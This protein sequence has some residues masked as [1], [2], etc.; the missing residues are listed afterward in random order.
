VSRLTCCCYYCAYSHGTI[1]LSNP[2]L[3][4][5]P[6]NYHSLCPHAH[7]INATFVSIT[8]RYQTH[9][10]VVVLQN[11]QWVILW[12]TS[13]YQDFL[14]VL[15]LYISL[16]MRQSSGWACSSN[17]KKKTTV[18]PLSPSIRSSLF[19]SMPSMAISDVKILVVRL[20]AI[21]L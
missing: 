21:W 20:F 10:V 3:M 2:I 1:V 16:V 7:G 8:A 4:A 6:F 19:C 11:R 17:D 12:T 15:L 14:V 5:L 18:F 9:L 13:L